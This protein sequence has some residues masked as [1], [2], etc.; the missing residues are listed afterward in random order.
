MPDGSYP[1]RV[2]EYSDAVRSAR[3]EQAG[4]PVRMP[5]DRSAA[6]RRRR[7]RDDAIEV[8]DRV[9]ES[10]LRLAAGKGQR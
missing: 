1:E 8:P 4:A 10:L 9:H 6:E 5:F 7:L 3:P 2:T